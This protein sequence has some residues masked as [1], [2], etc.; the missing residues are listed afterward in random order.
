MER[1]ATF[2]SR[3]VPSLPCIRKLLRSNWYCDQSHGADCWV[4]NTRRGSWKIPL[5]HPPSTVSR[6]DWPMKPKQT[7]KRHVRKDTSSIRN[8][9]GLDT[10]GIVETWWV[11]KMLFAET[12][13]SFCGRRPSFATRV[14][15]MN[16][17]PVFKIIIIIMGHRRNMSPSIST[18]VVHLPED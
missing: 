7:N 17:V 18:H 2:G 14:K 6:L 10:L 12:W 8:T 16:C 5:Y 13:E 11:M 3:W 1:G 15:I 4:S 9:G